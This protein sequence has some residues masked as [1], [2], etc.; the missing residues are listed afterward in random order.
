MTI[1][2]FEENMYNIQYFSIFRLKRVNVTSEMDPSGGSA[3]FAWPKSH[4]RNGTRDE[5]KHLDRL[6]EK[7]IRV[8]S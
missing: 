7:Q 5:Q 4:R 1:K 6:Y 8:F 2:I 3:R